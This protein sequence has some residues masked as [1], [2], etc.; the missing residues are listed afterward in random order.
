MENKN[1]NNENNKCKDCGCGCKTEGSPSL[2]DI[3]LSGMLAD[4]AIRGFVEAMTEDMPEAAPLDL[5]SK[6]DYQRMD[7]YLEK[8]GPLRE[9]IDEN[10]VA[11]LIA[12]SQYEK[13]DFDAKIKLHIANNIK[14]GM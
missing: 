6:S 4:V 12:L 7:T 5:L 11:L 8:Y 10:Y 13:V 9:Y 1:I 3:L 14:S 2:I